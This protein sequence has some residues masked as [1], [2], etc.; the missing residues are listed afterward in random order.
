MAYVT[1]G[2]LLP[3]E[4]AASRFGGDGYSTETRLD[5]ELRKAFAAQPQAE[6]PEDDASREEDI[7]TEGNRARA[8]GAPP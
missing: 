5:V 8:S 4:V 2:V 1:A 6:A 7:E 3:E